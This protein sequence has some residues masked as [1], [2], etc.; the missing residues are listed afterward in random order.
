MSLVEF[1]QAELENAGLFDSDSDY[2]GMIG[3]A[4]M[5]V[6][7]VFSDQGHSGFSGSIMLQILGKILDFKPL[8]PLT[9]DDNEWTKLNHDEDDMRYQNKRCPGVFKD[10]DGRA[11]NINGK[12]FVD[13]DGDAYTCLLY[14]SPSPRDS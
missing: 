14:T 8:T 7:R 5:K 4:A 9:G 2:D 6:V 1:A 13:S 12:V 10:S 11:Y 3:E